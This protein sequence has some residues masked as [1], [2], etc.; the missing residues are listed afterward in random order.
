MYDLRFNIVDGLLQG[1]LDGCR[2]SLTCGSGGRA[3][4]KT[5][6]AVNWH[7]S[8]NP[9]ATHIGGHNS[10]GTHIFGPL[11][12]GEYTLSTREKDENWIVLT[13]DAATYTFDRSGFAIHGRGVVGSHGCIVVNDFL[14][15]TR[16]YDSVVVR[17][18][19]MAANYRLQVVAVGQDLGRQ[20]GTA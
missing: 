8:G 11:P 13:P 4:S 2:F 16:M 10:M 6:G 1:F 20:F 5:P 3:G 12:I 18:K 7:L 19:V 9:L 17:Q 15:L 14:Q